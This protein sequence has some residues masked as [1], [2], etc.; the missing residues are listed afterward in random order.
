MAFEATAVARQEL[1]PG[2]SATFTAT[3]VPCNRG[4]VNHSDES[5]TFVLAGS[6]CR[7]HKANY[8][9][10]FAANIAVLTG[11]TV[12]EISVSLSLD[13]AALPASTMIVTPAAVEQFF[14]ISR[15]MTVPVFSNCCQT[16]T[17]T[18]T[19]TIPIAMSNAN[20]VIDRPD[21]R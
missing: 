18:N 7:R 13:G 12:G 4:I 6:K 15:A 19:S 2:Q 10:D 16:L 9:V 8:F 21:L 20:I 11:E 1:Q 14:N 17:V 3:V 5:P